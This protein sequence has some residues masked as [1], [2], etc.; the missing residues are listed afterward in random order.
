M[1]FHVSSCF[2]L[3]LHIFNFGYS[4]LFFPM[5]T[6]SFSVH[7]GGACR[8]DIPEPQDLGS[9]RAGPVGTS[10]LFAQR[11]CA[12]FAHPEVPVDRH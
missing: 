1:F 6:F 2:L 5:L 4:I 12:P 10:S 8:W 11:L 3:L 9:Y 7:I